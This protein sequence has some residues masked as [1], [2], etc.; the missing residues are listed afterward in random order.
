MDALLTAFIATAIAQFGDKTQLIVALLVAR[1][2][3]PGTVLAGL[4]L[5]AI[6]SSGAA[7]AA[8]ALIGTTITSRAAGLLAALALLFAAV[9]GLMK[10]RWPA[11]AAGRTPLFLA[12]V[13]LCLAAEIGDR[14]QF[15]TFALAARFD[16]PWLTAAGA[17]AGMF[18][19]ALPAAMLAGSLPKA[20]PL[21]AIRLGGAS[22]FLVAGFFAAISALQLA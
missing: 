19:A 16:P 9:A 1:S 17:A 12:S 20:V 8:G 11:A 21:R 7:A 14:S 6:A 2:H 22:L 3:R 13:I 15:L 10:P 4:L 5:A 18:V